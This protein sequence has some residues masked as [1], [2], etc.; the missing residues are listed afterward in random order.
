MHYINILFHFFIDNFPSLKLISWLFPVSLVWSFS[1][2]Y[3]AG[4]LKIKFLWKTGYTRKLFHFLIFFSACLYQQLLGLPGVFILGWAVSIA[5]LYACYKGSNNLFYE[6]LAREKDA[7]YRTKYILYSYIATFIGGVLANL[8][9]GHY[10]I[11]GYA[12][13]GIAD[14][15]AEPVGIKWGRHV[16][17][18]VSFDKKISVKSVEGSLAI[19]IS[20][21]ISISM[22][23]YSSGVFVT[24]FPMIILIAFVCTIVE[25]FSPSGTDNALLQLTASF[26]CS[27]F[28]Y[29]HL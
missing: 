1:V 26:L 19:M 25:A 11:F 21:I 15:I 24:A 22:I 12:V 3:L 10:A 9:F 8:L 20:S 23:V 4:S 6:A 16:Y 28:I 27:E 5:V 18:A 7:P 17:K 13:T 29:Q 2:L 14:A